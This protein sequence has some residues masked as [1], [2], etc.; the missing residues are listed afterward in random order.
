[1]SN[2]SNNTPSNNSPS[3]RTPL[4]DMSLYLTRL[5][6]DDP[7]PP[8]L[9]TLRA[10]QLRHTIAF[11]FENLS[12]L[13]RQ[14]V[15]LDLP[16]L[17]RKLLHD[18]RGGYCYELNQLFL[19]LLQQLGFQARSIAGRVVMN[20]PED[21]MTPRTHQALLVEL[22]GVSWLV[23]VGFGGLVPTAPLRLDTEDAQATPHERFRITRRGDNHVLRVEVA[24]EWRA[25]YI[26]DLQPQSEVDH[27][28][29]NW[30]VSTHPQSS[31]HD[32]LVAARIEP[33]LRH[34]L[35]GVRYTAHRIGAAS[36]QRRLDS[37]DAVI[38]TLQQVFHIRVP[39]HPPLHDAIAR[40]LAQD[41]DPA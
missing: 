13:L 40:L 26:F 41:T 3:S 28:V 25:L 33:G 32:R 18:G 36:E 7:P 31:F 6:H 15:V 37:V 8:T 2:T 17:Q 19:V 16:S 1:M 21:R 38:D 10:L 29:G 5:G 11:P 39:A 12:M 4:T 27:E 20:G 14:P 23:D 35:N 22:D 24:G 9:D 34:T 30:Y